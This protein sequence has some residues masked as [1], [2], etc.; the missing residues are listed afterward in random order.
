MSGD[1]LLVSAVIRSVSANRSDVSAIIRSVSDY[2]SV[3]SAVARSVSANRSDVSAVIRS[4]SDY[5]SVVSAVIG[6]VSV[7]AFPTPSA[8]LWRVLTVSLIRAAL[9]RSR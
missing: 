3:M 9:R 1:D 6:I 4:V 5:I 7:I 2:T 8:V